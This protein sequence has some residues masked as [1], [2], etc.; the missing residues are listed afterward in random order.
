ME[1]D[2]PG[3]LTEPWC[4]GFLLRVIY[5]VTADHAQL[6]SVTAPLE[7]KLCCVAQSPRAK[8]QCSTDY[9]AWSEDPR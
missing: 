7:V 8:L 6:I 3:I 1:S 9:S 2:Q 4:P 5:I